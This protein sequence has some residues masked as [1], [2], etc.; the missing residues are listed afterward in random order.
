MYNQICYMSNC[1]DNIWP[2]KIDMILE[3]MSDIQGESYN[4][5]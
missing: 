5:L 2:P 1:V 4:N 3:V